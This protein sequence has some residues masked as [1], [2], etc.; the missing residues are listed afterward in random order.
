MI[1]TEEQIQKIREY[2][3]A[4][5]PKPVPVE[6]EKRGERLSVEMKDGTTKARPAKFSR[7]HFNYTPR[8]FRFQGPG[9]FSIVL[10]YIAFNDT[11]SDAGWVNGIRSYPVW[12][13]HGSDSSRSRNSN[14]IGYQSCH[15]KYL[16]SAGAV[17]SE[18]TEF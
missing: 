15:F 10:Q 14:Y 9:Q 2:L 4:P 8:Y 17:L 5:A 3:D 18:M 6:V 12:V 1:Q 7:F 13:P 16:Y 11:G